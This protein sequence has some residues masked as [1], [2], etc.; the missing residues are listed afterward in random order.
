MKRKYLSTQIGNEYRNWNKKKVLISAPTGMGKTTFILE[1][2]APYVIA[3]GGKVLILC[4]RKLLRQ[5][6]WFDLVQKY[7]TYIELNNSVQIMTYQAL[8]EEIRTRS[9]VR[10]LFCEYTAVVCDEVH[11]F[12]SDSDFNGYGTFALLQAIILAGMAKTMLFLSAT[13]DEV[14]PLICS[15]IDIC[16]E[17]CLQNELCVGD[18]RKLGEIVEKDFSVLADY[19]RF[20]CIS[21]P[22]EESLC[23]ILAGSSKKSVL[24]VNDKSRGEHLKEL[25]IKTGK[26]QSQDIALL[27]ADNL[28]ESEN[29]LVVANL[30]IAHR[31]IPK[32]LI[33]TAV[34]DNGVSLHDSEIGNLLILTES[35]IE[36][37]QML[38]RVRVEATPECKL[39][40]LI[41]NAKFY[42]RRMRQYQEELERFEELSES[43]LDGQKDFYLGSF[44][45][46]Q[47]ERYTNF[48][49]RA[50]VL[51][52]SDF[53]FFVSSDK[54]SF[55][56]RGSAS[57][58]LNEFARQKTGNMY[59]MESRLYAL[60][61]ENPLKAVYE[62][63]SWID[64]EPEELVV[65]GSEYKERIEKE[66]VER[67]LSIHNVSNDEL[68][69]LK[70]QLVKE[71]KR[72]F[73]NDV[74]AKNG[75][76]SNEKLGEVCSRYGLFVDERE[77]T[78][79]KKRYSIL[80]KS[81]EEK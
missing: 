46:S 39:Y 14:K 23:E 77:G 52:S 15:T 5:Q 9:E 78:D 4:N 2:F 22:D 80:P 75:T 13:M 58:R 47:D 10:T 40:F 79:R 27:N 44:L 70:K 41:Q 69:E 1:C 56:R 68:V 7:E 67:L 51:T 50:L 55:V 12:Y 71:Y 16:I 38:G 26:I 33:T 25:L 11:Y 28:E 73:F 53:E 21:I 6:Y 49:K 36:F 35:K 37:L 65:F 45:T 42:Q 60:A 24:F 64:H 43:N 3:T 48:L 30:A 74:L 32:I 29:N 31:L 19:Q 18:Y 61:V 54:R 17:K 76:I 62:Q 8:A 63:M 59:L 81:K 66:F 20:Q 72:A 57:L 34:L